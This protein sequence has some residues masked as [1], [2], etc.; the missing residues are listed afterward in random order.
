M[1]AE[2]GR[3]QMSTKNGIPKLVLSCKRMV[4]SALS[5]TALP[6]FVLLGL[7][8]PM[9]AVAADAK[10]EMPAEMFFQ[11]AA[12][13][14]A[15]LSPSGNAVAFRVGA[16]GSRDRL[17]V[18]DLETKKVL[19]VASFDDA[20]VSEFRW[21]NDHRLVFDL[22]DKR[23]ALGD[24]R[25]AWGLYA[26]NADGTGYRQLV[27]RERVGMSNGET[28]RQL[29]PNT[30]MIPARGPQVGDS[31]YVAQPQAWA[32][33]GNSFI[34]L[35]SLNTVTG[36]AQEMD[37]PPQAHAWLLDKAGEVRAV[38]TSKDDKSSI[39]W[40]DP[41]NGQWR[42]LREFK[43]YVPDGDMR[44][45]QI[46]ADGKLYVTSR[47]RR[48]KQAVFIYDPVTDTVADKPLVAATQYDVH[49]RFIT[50]NDAL[51]GVRYTVDAVVTQWL[52]SAMTAH[53]TE[54][55][56]L[57]PVTS[58]LLTPP[59]RGE[60]P[61]MLVRAF[62]DVQPDTFWVYNTSTKKLLRLGAEHPDFSPAQLARMSQMDMVRFK[63]RDGLEIPSYLTLPQGSEVKKNLPLIVYVHG[64]PWVRGATWHWQAEVQFLAS[65]GYA[66]MQPEFRG[67]TGFGLK[68]L[69]AGFKQW[70]LAMQDD[71][72]DAARWA[73]AQGIADPKRICIMGA[74][75]GG[76][77]T[78]MGLAKDGDLFKCGVEWVGVSDLLLYFD[79]SWSDFSDSWKQ[80]GASQM[81]GDR[82]KDA[83]QLEATS[84]IKLAA[85][86]K[87]PLLMAHGRIDRRVPIEHGKRM[88][89]AVKAH[90]AN[91]E[92]V[93]YDKDGHGW[94]LPETHVDWWTRVEKFLD[95]HIGAAK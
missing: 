68:H 66:V 1:P 77:A 84:P 17:A 95:R 9:H 79:A 72:A 44:L 18:L 59:S 19:P 74:S 83:A 7:S 34:K 51:L 71:L 88:Y 39:Q 56:K 67:S 76:Y 31:I 46:N 53:Q 49:P 81:V 15:V 90:N 21:I 87:N 91:V 25:F 8:A 2:R 48:D 58:N 70:G 30:Y 4:R 45:E 22:V 93:Q 16:K 42:T 63:A 27:A 73:I 89:D 37:T 41:A 57:L 62:S 10:V 52:D 92:W 61:W 38:E 50:R 40:R 54:V 43:R 86:I 85:K 12:F 64:G 14:G 82:E 26:V 24:R 55:D 35:F 69:K 47:T 60:G 80:F 11:Q 5:V 32:K 33:D 29:P 36:L 78:L 6:L 20:D 13:S 28:T 75:Y 23:L 65:R 3:K 94:S